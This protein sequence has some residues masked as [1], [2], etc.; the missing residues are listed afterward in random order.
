MCVKRKSLRYE[1]IFIVDVDLCVYGGLTQ[2]NGYELKIGR[3]LSLRDD[4][5]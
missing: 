2:L 5:I 4:Y 1:I 3:L